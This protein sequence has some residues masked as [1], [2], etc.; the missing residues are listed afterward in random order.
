M[1]SKEIAELIKD[2]YPAEVKDITEF[3]GQASVVVKKDRIKEA[4]LNFMW[5]TP[6]KG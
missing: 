6:H 4:L 5:V 3:R 2:R 1:E